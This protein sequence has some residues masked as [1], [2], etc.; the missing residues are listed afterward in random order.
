MLNKVITPTSA[1]SLYEHIKGYFSFANQ[2]NLPGR[3]SDPGASLVNL[4][5]TE[6]QLLL[7]S[8]DWKSK[9]SPCPETPC[10]SYFII[11]LSVE[12]AVNRVVRMTEDMSSAS[13]V[14]M[15]KSYRNRYC[16]QNANSQAAEKIECKK[17]GEKKILLQRTNNKL[18]GPLGDREAVGEWMLIRCQVL[19]SR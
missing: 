19:S 15:R 1:V 10:K 4:M 12:E 5:S 7:V 3:A 6:L 16:T 18:E 2:G 14:S 9:L 13:W 17:S 8:I 11:K